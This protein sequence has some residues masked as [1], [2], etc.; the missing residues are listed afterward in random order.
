M[1]I[2]RTM[3]YNPNAMINNSHWYEVDYNDN[4]YP[5]LMD[6]FSKAIPVMRNSGYD[7]AVISIEFEG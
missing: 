7:I 2:I 1:T 4:D 6:T 5:D 3:F